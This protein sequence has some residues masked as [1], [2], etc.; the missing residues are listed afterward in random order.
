MTNA[1]ALELVL[2]LCYTLHPKNAPSVGES[3]FL[4]SSEVSLDGNDDLQI[5]PRE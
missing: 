2:Q 3:S 4:P 5:G 1:S